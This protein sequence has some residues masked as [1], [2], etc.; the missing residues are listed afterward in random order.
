MFR[1]ELTVVSLLSAG[2]AR[3]APAPGNRP[4]VT[5]WDRPVDPDKDCKFIRD[6]S[7]DLSFHPARRMHLWSPTAASFLIAKDVP[8]R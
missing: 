4:W 3:A 5:G 1:I 7:S 2:I 8:A 6:L